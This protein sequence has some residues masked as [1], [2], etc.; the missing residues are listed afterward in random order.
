MQGARAPWWPRTKASGRD[1][2]SRFSRC[3]VVMRRQRHARRDAYDSIW[4]SDHTDNKPAPSAALSSSPYGDAPGTR[5]SLPTRTRGKAQRY[6]VPGPSAGDA[7]VTATAAQPRR[8]VSLGAAP[9]RPPP[10]AR[11]HPSRQREKKVSGRQRRW[12]S[13]ADI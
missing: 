3:R 12:E 2:T 11:G 1:Q 4:G 9:R 5:Q 6:F 8:A 13:A 10:R 7:P